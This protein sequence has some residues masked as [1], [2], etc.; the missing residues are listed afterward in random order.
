MKLLYKCG[1]KLVGESV[2][3]PMSSLI[4]EL[5][6]ADYAVLTASIRQDITEVTIKLQWVIAFLETKLSVVAGTRIV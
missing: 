6:F 5:C 3:T 4:T 2:R 1:R